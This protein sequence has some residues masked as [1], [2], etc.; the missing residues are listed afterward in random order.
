MVI[1]A[2]GMDEK[3]FLKWGIKSTKILESWDLRIK[4]VDQYPMFHKIKNRFQF[5]DKI[6]A[7][8]SDLLKMQYMTH[9]RV[10]K[11]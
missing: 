9:L 8:L 1:Q 4:R 7:W 10:V 6:M 5:K 3:S 2:S 11:N